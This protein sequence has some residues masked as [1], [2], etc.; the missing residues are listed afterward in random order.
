MAGFG[1]KWKEIGVTKHHWISFDMIVIFSC[2]SILYLA[3]GSHAEI[4]DFK[5][6]QWIMRNAQ[7]VEHLGREC[8][9]G[10]A[11]LKDVEFDNGTI[12]VDFA[13]TRSVSYPG[14]IFRVQSDQNMERL[15]IRPHRAGLYE[16]ALQYTPTINGVAGWQLYNGSG[17]TTG[18]DFPVDEWVH[19]KVEVLGE[20]ARVFVNNSDEPALVIDYLQHGI[21]KGTVGVLGP[22]DGTAYFSNFSYTIDNSLEFVPTLEIDTPPGTITNWEVSQ[23]YK[24]SEIDLETYYGIQNITE[25]KWKPVESDA[26]GLVDI[27]RS[28]GRSG[29]EPD[30][31][32]AKTT[33]RADADKIME[34]QYGYSDVVTIFLN[35]EVL[36]FGNSGYKQRDSSF[37][38]VVGLNDGVYLRLKKGENE[39]VL[40]IAESFG[41][42]GFICRDGDAFYQSENL[43]E[44]ME[45][46]GDF[47]TPECVVYDKDRQALF[48]SN[49]DI[50]NKA[51]T[52]GGQYITKL[53][54]DGVVDN[55]KWHAGL[56]K[57]TG[58]AI[59]G[60][61]LYIVDRTTLSL[62]DIIA[63]KEARRVE[64]PGAEFPN[65]IDIDENGAAYISDSNRGMIY[66]FT[67]D[68]FEEWFWGEEVQNPNGILVYNGKLYYGN[69]GDNSVKAVSLTTRE[70]ETIAK[71]K[72]GNI[73]GIQMTSK[74]D[75]LVSHWEGRIYRISLAGE[76]EKIL[77]LSVLGVNTADFEYIPEK[78]MIAV[79]TFR[80]NRV[81]GYTL[82]D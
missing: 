79:P 17:F 74:G 13:V 49:F 6:D 53:T 51:R 59:H 32:F 65:D 10:F 62:I 23:S 67:D 16:D 14:I 2:L 77:D 58:L 72:P 36:A 20:Q 39:L 24:L 69:N 27:A 28:N 66:K 37:L 46:T 34:L 68:G 80:D 38:G 26:T 48:V 11:Y 42:W 61:Y 3:P 52:S 47:L 78:E 8:L 71:L 4:I 43:V 70:A 9:M 1:V 44:V 30:V 41:G 55:L 12:E 45:T 60:N 19:L 76:V 63:M 82:S 22:A 40:V 21:S 57:P 54:M 75:L 35:G 31:V 5:S 15:Y 81:V 73:D 25:I 56:N 33:I 50:Y 7:I 18:V 29:G 64:I